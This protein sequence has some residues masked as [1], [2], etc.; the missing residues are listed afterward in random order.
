MRILIT[1]LILLVSGC[2]NM[3]TRPQ[4]TKP[5]MQVQPPNLW[6]DHKQLAISVEECA[7]KGIR[8]LESLSFNRVVKNGRYS[9]G[10]FASNRAAVKCVENEYGSFVYVSVAGPEKKVVERLRNELIGQMK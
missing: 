6:S 4:P 7:D 2:V 3:N 10:N 1:I 8:A 9:Y 5:Q